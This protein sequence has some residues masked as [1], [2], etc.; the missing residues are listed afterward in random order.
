MKN[1]LQFVWELLTHPYD[2]L[3]LLAPIQLLLAI[4]CWYF[5]I[6]TFIQIYKDKQYGTK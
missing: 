2:L 5:I 3:D 6:Q 4:V 1:Y